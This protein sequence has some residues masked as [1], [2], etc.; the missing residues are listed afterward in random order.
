VTGVQTCALPIS[1]HV[2]RYNPRFVTGLELPGRMPIEEVLFF[3]VIPICGLLTYSAENSML[4]RL[5]QLR[6]RDTTESEP[7]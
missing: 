5:R 1:A 6:R 4:D 2:W 3:V 7:R